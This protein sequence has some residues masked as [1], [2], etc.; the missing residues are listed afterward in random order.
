MQVDPVVT[1]VHIEAGKV[2]LDPLRS[3]GVRR[4]ATWIRNGRNTGMPRG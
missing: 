3:R 1:H 4:S 2:D